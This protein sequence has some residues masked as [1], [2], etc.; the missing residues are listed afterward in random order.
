[1]DGWMDGLINNCHIIII[2]IIIIIIF[3]I[4]PLETVD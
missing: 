4:F 3:I 2:I 1:M